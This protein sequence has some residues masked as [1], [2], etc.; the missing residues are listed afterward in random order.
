MVQPFVGRET[1]PSMAV[2]HVACELA[3]SLKVGFREIQSAASQGCCFPWQGASGA[4]VWTK[5]NRAIFY[6]TKDDL[7]R[8]YKVRAFLRP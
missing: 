5:D 6:V 4:V 3:S 1:C 8:P 7:D 2:N